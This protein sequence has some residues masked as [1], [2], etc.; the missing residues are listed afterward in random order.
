[1]LFYHGLIWRFWQIFKKKEYDMKRWF[2]WIYG[3]FTVVFVY[4]SKTKAWFKVKP[5]ARVC[6]GLLI[7]K[8][9]N[10]AYPEG[11]HT[12]RLD[13]QQVKDVKTTSFWR[14]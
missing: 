1:M 7:S 14:C 5:L 6:L 12:P 11:V 8:K 13:A 3:I 4:V 9:R 2:I 10:K